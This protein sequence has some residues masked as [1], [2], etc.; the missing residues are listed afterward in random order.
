MHFNFGALILSAVGVY[1]LLAAFRVV[2]LSK[3]PE[4]NELWL[5]K[6]GTMMKIVSPLAILFGLGQFLGLFN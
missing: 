2:R 1:G 5:R 4:A 6:F 3:N